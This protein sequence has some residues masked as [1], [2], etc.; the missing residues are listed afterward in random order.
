MPLRQI[1]VKEKVDILHMRSRMPAWIGYIA[2]KMILP[3]KR[4]VLVT[5]F[6]GFYSVNRYSAIMTQGDGVIAVSKS[7]KNHIREKYG[8]SQNV[9]LIFRGVDVDAFCPEN[10]S[11]ERK[12]KLQKRWNIPTDRPLLMLPGR[13][14]KLKGQEVFLES[15]LKV[16]NKNYFAVLVGDI[17][18]N[19]GYTALL[20]EFIRNHGL[21]DRVSLVGHCD[22]MP[23][24]FMLADIVLSTS[25]L[26]PEAF[27]RTSV[28]A[29]AMGKPVIATAH[30]GSMETVLPGEN[31]WL[32]RP[33]AP[34]ELA[35][36]I[37]EALSV[38]RSTLQKLGEAGRNRVHECFTSTAMCEHTLK[39]YRYLLGEQP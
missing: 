20:R 19:P 30:G 8:R 3:A 1:L 38:D 32:V 17:E 11:V 5:T 18:D 6:H 29:M 13:L 28:E 36:A 7:I 9:Q 37:D 10:V 15:L 39:F 12:A 16:K 22:D 34:Q 26:E 25:S 4:P 21:D 14:S 24:A 35:L 2:W 33:S 31:G 27:G 23:A